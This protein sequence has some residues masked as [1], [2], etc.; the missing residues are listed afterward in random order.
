MNLDQFAGKLCAPDQFVKVSFGGFAG[1]G[2]TRTASEF[3]KGIYK[4]MNLKKP[5]L[6][7][8]N[9]KGSRFLVPFFQ[10]AKIPVI[11]KETVHLADILM[12]IEFLNNK[13]IDFLFV[14]SLTKVWYQFCKD[15][16]VKN[17]RKFMTLQDWGKVIPEWQHRF[18]DRYVEAAGN[19]C[20]TGR[21]GYEYD[22]TVNSENGKK[23]F[24]KSGV[25]MKLAG[26]TPF[27]PDLNVW[28][29]MKQEIKNGN[30]HQWRE[31]AFLKDRSGVLD[32][33]TV[34]NPTYAD[35]KPFVDFILSVE[36]GEVEKETDTTNLVPEEY[37]SDKTKR[38]ILVENIFGALENKYPGTTKENKAKKSELKK[39]VF[40]TFSDTE[41]K[42]SS[43]ADLE[44]GYNS[45]L[46][47]LQME[48]ENTTHENKNDLP[49]DKD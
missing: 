45:I 18:A 36:T 14:D 33:Q 19:F 1:S 27:E 21:G 37:S 46:D 4:D 25:K 24:A 23:E 22:L 2:K 15:Y 20:F 29:E 5:L 48:I 12:A 38:D 49:F 16:K 6:F 41:I 11:V 7:I 44:N 42:V 40:G 28:M 13:E 10:K 31:C 17:H 9:E 35:F 34:I 8:D 32:G 43:L 30:L 3:I 39:Q 26:E 47:L